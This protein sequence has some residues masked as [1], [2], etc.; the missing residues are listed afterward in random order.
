[1]RTFA[2]GKYLPLLTR[3]PTQRDALVRAGVRIELLTVAWM[4]LEAAVAIGAG[5][6]AR[7]VALTGFGLDSVIELVTGGALLWRLVTEANGGSLERVERAEHRAAWV[8]GIALVLLCGYVVAT[9]ALSLLTRTHA[10]SSPIGIGLAVVAVVGMPVLAWRK[11]AIAVPLGS[12]ALRGDAACS[13]TCAYMAGTLLVGLSLNA[14]FGWWW[15]DSLA[16]LGLLIWLVPE[17]REVIEGARA[18]RGACACGE[19]GCDD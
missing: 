19:D 8:T 14:L 11:R 7:S 18:G 2:H 1:V 4:V 6:V 10:E 13:I 17:A 3:V 16:A 15:A 12:P 5:I 9:A